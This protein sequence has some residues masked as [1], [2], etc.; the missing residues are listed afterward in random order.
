M[1][2]LPPPGA[3]VKRKERVPDGLQK[4][5]FQV[6]SRGIRL[7]ARKLVISGYVR[8]IEVLRVFQH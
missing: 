7:K 2:N 1:F 6:M 3:M 4:M 5:L 8:R